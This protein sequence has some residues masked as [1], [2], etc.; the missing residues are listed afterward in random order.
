[1][2]EMSAADSGIAEWGGSLRRDDGVKRKKE[3][4][5][6]TTETGRGTRYA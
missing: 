6:K 2:R 1:M 5:S 3:G 4:K